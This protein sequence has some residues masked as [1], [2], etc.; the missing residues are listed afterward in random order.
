MEA[1]LVIINLRDVV[2]QMVR[3]TKERT[4]SHG[5]WS[6]LWERYHGRCTKTAWKL[7]SRSTL[8]V[9]CTCCDGDVVERRDV[10]SILSIYIQLLTRDENSL[11]ACCITFFSYLYWKDGL[12]IKIKLMELNTAPLMS[13][14]TYKKI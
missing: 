13:I 11:N 8:R 12:Y 4:D 5:G 9:H 14:G 6:K 1:V 10:S 3:T 2:E 7:A